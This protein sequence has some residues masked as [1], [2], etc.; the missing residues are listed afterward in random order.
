MQAAADARKSAAPAVA[1]SLS[2]ASGGDMSHYYKAQHADDW[3]PQLGIPSTVGT[4]MT[5]GYVPV[6]RTV[7]YYNAPHG[8]QTYAASSLL[9]K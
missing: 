7:N 2:V 9:S 5:G 1:Q 6:S 8:A 3:L 4:A